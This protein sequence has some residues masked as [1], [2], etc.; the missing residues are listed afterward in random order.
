[1]DKQPIA[2]MSYA[3]FDDENDDKF[4]TWFCQCLS[5]EVRAQA[6]EVFSI[7]QDKTDIQWGQNWKD[8]IEKS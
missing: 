7:F 5:N 8:R 4:C 2:F 1:M 3:R 6:G